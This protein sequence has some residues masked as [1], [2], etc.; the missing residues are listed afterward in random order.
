M[1]QLRCSNSLELRKWKRIGLHDRGR[2]QGLPHIREGGSL[3]VLIHLARM[4]IEIDQA[5]IERRSADA[6]PFGGFGPITLCL[7]E[8][9][10]QFRFLV[11]AR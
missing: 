2:A 3:V 8:G 6:Q 1:R 9:G 7:G 5:A 10:K 4:N 11:L